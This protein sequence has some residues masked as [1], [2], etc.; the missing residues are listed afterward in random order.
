MLSS[1]YIFIPV[2]GCVSR[3]TSELFCPGA[4][5][6]V[7]TAMIDSSLYFIV[8]NGTGAV[9]MHGHVGQLPGAPRAYGPLTN[10]CMLCTCF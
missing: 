7:K 5:S 9:L 1:I 2:S 4:N 10:L 8:D 3:G 6:A